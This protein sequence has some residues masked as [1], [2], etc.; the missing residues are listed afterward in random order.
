MRNKF[1]QLDQFI[2]ETGLVEVKNLFSGNSVLI[3]KL[4]T[5]IS[6]LNGM[7]TIKD[8]QFIENPKDQISVYNKVIEKKVIEI[9]KGDQTFIRILKYCS[10]IGLGLITFSLISLL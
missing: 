7:V 9:G 6:E 5:A 1:T 2:C 10:A 4:K 3:N 8:N